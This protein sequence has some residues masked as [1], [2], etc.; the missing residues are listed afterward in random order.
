MPFY[1]LL[2]PRTNQRTLGAQHA[3]TSHPTHAHMASDHHSERKHTHTHVGTIHTLTKPPHYYP[4]S[5]A[6]PLRPLQPHRRLK[7]SAVFGAARPVCGRGVN[8]TA[9]NYG[10]DDRYHSTRPGRSP[11]LSRRTVLSGAE[12][13]WNAQGKAADEQGSGSGRSRPTSVLSHRLPSGSPPTRLPA[14]GARRH[15]PPPRSLARPA[16]AAET[17]SEGSQPRPG[18]AVESHGK[19]SGNAVERRRQHSGNAV[20]STDPGGGPGMAT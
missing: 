1:C 13:Q 5:S 19:G 2:E 14:A 16:G 7:Q 17:P 8:L 6:G 10:R 11:G 9:S 18:Q 12:R 15:G 20:A 3:A 4:A